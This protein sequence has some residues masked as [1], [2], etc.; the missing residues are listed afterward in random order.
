M[1]QTLARRLLGET[2][3]SSPTSKMLSLKKTNIKS[4]KRKSTS[5]IPRSVHSWSLCFLLLRRRRR[6]SNCFPSRSGYLTRERIQ[7]IGPRSSFRSRTQTI[8]DC[9]SK[10]KQTQRRLNFVAF[11]ETSTAPTLTVVTVA[12][13]VAL[14]AVATR[15][16]RAQLA[17]AVRR[18]VPCR[19]QTSGSGGRN[20]RSRRRAHTQQMPRASPNSPMP[21]IIWLL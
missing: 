16:P 15:V 6:R 8:H 20:H 13:H 1:L 9:P 17:T 2:C 18:L 19:G 7:T 3:V 4:W 21:P 12:A 5:P 11:E 14:A 10:P